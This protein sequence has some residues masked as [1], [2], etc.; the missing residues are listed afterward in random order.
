MEKAAEYG[1]FFCIPEFEKIY[2]R[3]GWI[4]LPDASIILTDKSGKDGVLPHKKIANYF[5]LKFATLP[6]RNIHLQG[7]DW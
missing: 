2:E 4:K 7:N 3:C 5:P 6:A 1:F